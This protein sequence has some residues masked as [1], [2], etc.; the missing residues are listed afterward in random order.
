MARIQT[1]ESDSEINGL[2][3]VIGSDGKEGPTQNETKNFTVDA[4]SGYILAHPVVL[5]GIIEASSDEEAASAGVP[6]NGIYKN[7]GALYIREV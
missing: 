6:I 4:L 3:K 5:T 2:D 1:Y 7:S